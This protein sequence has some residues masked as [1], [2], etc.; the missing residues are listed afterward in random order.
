M[1]FAKIDRETAETS[2]DLT[3]DLDGIGD[4]SINTGVGFLDHM[5]TLFSRHGRFD[6]QLKCEG[7][8]YV[9]DHHS[10]EDIGICLGKA[11]S[12]AL[13]SSISF[14]FVS[15]PSSMLSHTSLSPEWPKR[16]TLI[17][18]LPSSVRRF[19]ASINS[20]LKRVLPQSVMTL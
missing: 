12:Q 15:V 6:I 7:D 20:S 13:S 8:T 19:C 1:R 18:M 4:S 11:F 10:V 17:T 5:L 9:D 16:P 3:L 2:I 14:V